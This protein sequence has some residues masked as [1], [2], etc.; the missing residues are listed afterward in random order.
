MSRSIA[1]YT[2]IAIGLWLLIAPNGVAAEE[3][4]MCPVCGKMNRQD[5]TYQSKAGM[6]LARGTTNALLGWTELI[7]QPATEAKSG[8]N[9]FVG[10]ARGLG[11]SVRRTL[12]GAGEVLT[13]WTP[14]VNNKYLY[15][16][17]DCPVCMGRHSQASSSTSGQTTQ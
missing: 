5:T 16:A 1:R 8:G 12:S 4:K 10:I 15:F 13:F 7:R 17:E 3:S 6:T 14:K 2:G 11:Q 9:V